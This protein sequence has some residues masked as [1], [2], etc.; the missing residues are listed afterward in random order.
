MTR[1]EWLLYYADH[2]RPNLLEI[3]NEIKNLKK[4]LLIMTTK[5]DVLVDLHKAKDKQ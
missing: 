3:E 4:E 5:Y 1:S 2:A